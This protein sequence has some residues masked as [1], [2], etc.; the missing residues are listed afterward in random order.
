MSMNIWLFRAK[1]HITFPKN[2]WRLNTGHCLTNISHFGELDIGYLSN[3]CP[4]VWKNDAKCP[5]TLKSWFRLFRAKLSIK[6]IKT[7][8]LS[9]KPDLNNFWDSFKKKIFSSHPKRWAYDVILVP[10]MSQ[11]WP[12]SPKM[13]YFDKFTPLM[14]FWPHFCP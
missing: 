8:Y 12:F 13:T 3:N 5:G 4:W 1:Y 2:H 11:I 10:K 14:T 7:P 9:N 6:Q